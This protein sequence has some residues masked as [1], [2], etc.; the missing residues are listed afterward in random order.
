LEF[1]EAAKQKNIVQF[2]AAAAVAEE[3][4]A[5]QAQAG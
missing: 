3:P 2:S 4:A 1:Y 5:L